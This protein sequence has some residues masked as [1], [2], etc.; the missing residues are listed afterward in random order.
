MAVCSKYDIRYYMS[1]K[2]SYFLYILGYFLLFFAFV[3]VF[4]QKLLIAQ[5]ILYK[6]G[7]LI[8]YKKATEYLLSID[9]ENVRVYKKH[10]SIYKR[11]AN[12][13]YMNAG[14]YP[15]FILSATLTCGNGYMDIKDNMF[16]KTA[17]IN[18]KEFPFSCLALKSA[19][20]LNSSLKVSQN[21]VYGF[22]AFKN[23]YMRGYNIKNLSLEFNRDKFT[24]R[25]QVDI[26]DL[27]SHIK[28]DGL[29]SINEYDIADSEISGNCIVN[30]PFKP[31]NLTISGTLIN[32]YISLK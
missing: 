10:N 30:A 26:L 28:G 1:S 16:T 24:F 21:G 19:G 31:L 8:Y 5:Y 14:F 32:P 29:V 12:I 25:G 3:V 20:V 17:F 7:Y 23:M 13:D 11:V 18:T 4:T 27:T 15:P 2:F 6:N 22:M 9:M